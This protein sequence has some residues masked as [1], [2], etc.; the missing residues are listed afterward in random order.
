[1]INNCEFEGTV[2]S[3]SPLTA[4]ILE[5][6]AKVTP[7]FCFTLKHKNMEIP[8]HAVGYLAYNLASIIQPND[9]VYLKSTYK[10][11][12]FQGQQIFNA[13]VLTYLVFTQKDNI[14]LVFSDH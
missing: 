13:F 11:L 9:K 7:S 4:D 10:P 12:H 5:S 2:I 1:M 14:A 6:T 8:I 3:V